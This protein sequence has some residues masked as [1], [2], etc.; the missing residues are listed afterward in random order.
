LQVASLIF[1]LDPLGILG[2]LFIANLALFRRL[3]PN[4]LSKT[5]LAQG[6]RIFVLRPLR[7]TFKAKLVFAAIY[8]RYAFLRRLFQTDN[9]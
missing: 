2:A 3:Q 9:A 1:V 6:T 8:G 7:D 4:N 5:I